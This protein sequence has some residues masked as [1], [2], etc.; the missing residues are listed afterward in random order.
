MYPQPNDNWGNHKKT[1][2]AEMKMVFVLFCIIT[3]QGTFFL[4]VAVFP[5]WYIPIS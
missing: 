2:I 5:Q 3:P 4:I 1:A